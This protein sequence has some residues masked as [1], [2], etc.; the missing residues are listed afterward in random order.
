[1]QQWEHFVDDITPLTQP[2]DAQRHAVYTKV[3]Q[4]GQQGWEMVSMVSNGGRVWAAFK[5]PAQQAPAA[6][7]QSQATAQAPQ[8]YR[9]KDLS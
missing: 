1:M 2:A 4:L 8:P 6:P 9:G 3:Q 7:V 5:R